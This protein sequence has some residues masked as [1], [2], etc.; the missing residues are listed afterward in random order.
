MKRIPL[1]P[2]FLSVWVSVLLLSGILQTVKA[3]T[4]PVLPRLVF[5]P[6]SVSDQVI[7]LNK[8]ITAQNVQIASLNA[9]LAAKGTAN[10]SAATV[11]GQPYANSYT[12]DSHLVFALCEM[13]PL[14]GNGPDA[15]VTAGFR[16]EV[17]EAASKGIDGFALDTFD[18]GNYLTLD[19]NMIAA[20]DQ[21]NTAHTDASGT[22]LI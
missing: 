14:Y 4:N 5:N 11:Q 1:T 19:A 6:K 2:V 18:A 12:D 8:L 7:S 9:T 16:R 21:Y 20:I 17:D 13:A 10:P 15:I 3:Q 22:T